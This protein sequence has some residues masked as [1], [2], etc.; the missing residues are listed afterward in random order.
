M[1]VALTSAGNICMPEAG[2]I[3]TDHIVYQLHMCVICRCG[4]LVVVV[5]SEAFR[6]GL[7]VRAY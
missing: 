6:S 5:V 3:S 7:S 2:S 1:V 4:G